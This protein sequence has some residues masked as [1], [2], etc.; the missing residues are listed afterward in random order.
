MTRSST[1]TEPLAVEPID[2]I[3]SIFTARRDLVKVVKS[4]LA[5]SGL[6]IEECDL[7]VSLYGA[8]VLMWNDLEHDSEG[9]VTY[10]VLESFLVHNPCMLSRRV[11]KMTNHKPPLVEVDKAG[12]G[13][14]FNALRVRIT[15]A[16]IQRIVPVWERYS[17][18]AA[19]LLRGL[20][21]T[22]LQTHLAVNQEII[23]RI[24]ARRQAANDFTVD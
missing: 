21:Q 20:D 8:K 24:H 23:K 18:M 17:R 12:G 5:D 13:Q 11:R 22:T 1:I 4:V 15:D 14:H 16:G 9:Y 2:T 7:L 3:G 19:N 6:T 10:R